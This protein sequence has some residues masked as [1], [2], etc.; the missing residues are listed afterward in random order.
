M[1]QAIPSPRGALPGIG[2]FHLFARNPLAF[3]KAAHQQCGEHFKFKLLTR[4]AHVL[5]SPQGQQVFFNPPPGALSMKEAYRLTVPMFGK[6]VTYDLDP[7][8]F[9]QH[10]S[11]LHRLLNARAMNRHAE[12]C[13]EEV[14][15]FA[16]DLGD[17]GVFELKSAMDSVVTRIFCR[18]FIGDDFDPIGQTF[19]RMFND[20]EGGANPVAMVAPSFPSP[21]NRRRDRARA[22]IQELLVPLIKRRRQDQ[23]RADDG[24][25]LSQLI[26]AADQGI[27]LTDYQIVGI[28]LTLLFSA[29][30][31]TSAFATRC[32]MALMKNAEQRLVLEDETASVFPD[33]VIRY[34]GLRSLVSFERFLKEVERL[35]PSVAVLMR[36]AMTDIPVGERVIPKGAMVM[37][38]P[39][40]M[41]PSLTF[42]TSAPVLASTATVWPSRV[43]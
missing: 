18:C 10:M 3:L 7:E 2:H 26:A 31:T 13:L 16:G 33:G 11:M 14:D 19:Q 42:Q 1:R 8:T 40:L 5:I 6:G 29:R 35:Y 28:V 24:Y 12:V 43:L 27:P 37:V 9:D 39:M 17:Q 32:G 22:D 15:R 30:S 25:F 20:L 36:V 4:E 38:S 21:A 34:E 23:A 41:S